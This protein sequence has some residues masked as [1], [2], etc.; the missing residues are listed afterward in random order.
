MLQ[1]IG[2]SLY[3]AYN[4]HNFVNF[5]SLKSFLMYFQNFQIAAPKDRSHFYIFLQGSVF[6][7]RGTLAS[8]I[9]SWFVFLCILVYFGLEGKVIVS[10]LVFSD[11]DEVW[12]CIYKYLY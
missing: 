2:L 1:F 7:K 12:N 11:R 6:R 8:I 5:V 4:F 3:F 10:F 9:N